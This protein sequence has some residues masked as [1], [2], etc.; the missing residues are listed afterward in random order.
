M[1]PPKNE[2][3]EKLL[4]V[5][6]RLTVDGRVVQSFTNGKDEFLYTGIKCVW[7]GHY[8]EVRLTKDKDG[9]TRRLMDLTPKDLGRAEIS[10]EQQA[11][12]DAREMIVRNHISR[13]RAEQSAKRR[14]DQLGSELH[15]LK[16]MVRGLD[17]IEI[18]PFI[19]QLVKQLRKMK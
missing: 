6:R 19:N 7:S 18:S 11:E 17:W 3:T 2:K 12:W 14:V 13:R 9:E 16:K 10:D 15:A 4:Y 8:Y 5:G 1:K